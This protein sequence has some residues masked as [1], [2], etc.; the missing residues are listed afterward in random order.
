[1]NPWTEPEKVDDKIWDYV[2]SWFDLAEK[3]DFYEKEK[4]HE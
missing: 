3:Q 1:M 4:R 2:D